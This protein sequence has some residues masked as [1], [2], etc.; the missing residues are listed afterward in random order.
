MAKSNTT[1]KDKLMTLLAS[2]QNVS[3]T[4]LA[5]KLGV[6]SVSAHINN[7]RNEGVIIWTNVGRNGTSYR[8]DASRS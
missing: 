7:L 1:K 3:A 2:G 4:T 5:K 6:R 8:F